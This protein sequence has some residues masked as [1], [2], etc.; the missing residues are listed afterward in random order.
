MEWE[1][2]PGEAEGWGCGP[3]AWHA[4]IAQICAP[5]GSILIIGS[6]FWG[7]VFH[8]CAFYLSSASSLAFA[9]LLTQMLTNHSMS[10]CTPN[11]PW[12]YYPSF[13]AQIPCLY[14]LPKGLWP[15][16]NFSF[17]L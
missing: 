3:G 5:V 16:L 14:L 17:V 7:A 6:L 10:V 12:D 1:A 15:V 13:V 4:V 11:H 2:G 9:L 8:F